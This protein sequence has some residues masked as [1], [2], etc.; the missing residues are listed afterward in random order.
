LY[1]KNALIYSIG[2][3]RNK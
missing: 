1:D 2:V 3:D